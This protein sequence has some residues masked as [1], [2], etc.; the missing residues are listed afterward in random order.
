MN[1]DVN[2]ILVLLGTILFLSFISFIAIRVWVGFWDIFIG[3]IKKLN[4][5][6]KKK[7]VKWTRIKEE[8][9]THDE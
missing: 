9:S 2:Q 6:R 3:F 8:I 1:L 7:E 4:P 5:F